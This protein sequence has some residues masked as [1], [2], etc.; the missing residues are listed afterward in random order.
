MKTKIVNQKC[1]L[2]GKIIIDEKLSY[3]GGCILDVKCTQLIKT[4]N[5]Y[6]DPKTKDYWVENYSKT[7]PKFEKILNKVNKN[8]R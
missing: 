3:L 7:Y 5:N 6:K 2:C 8:L 4:F 1:E